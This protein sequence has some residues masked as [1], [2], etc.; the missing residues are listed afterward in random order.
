TEVPPLPSR[1]VAVLLHAGPQH[2]RGI[3][4]RRG[5]PLFPTEGIPEHECRSVLSIADGDVRERELTGLQPLASHEDIVDRSCRLPFG[6]ALAHRPPG[7]R[8]PP[9][10]P[11]RK[12]RPRVSCSRPLILTGCPPWSYMTGWAGRS[13]PGLPLGGAVGGARR[14][15]GTSCPV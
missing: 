14:A 4:K 8:G 3:V 15:P 12:R 5:Q 11:F 7:P 6:E 10:T 1:R 13:R 9:C 2:C